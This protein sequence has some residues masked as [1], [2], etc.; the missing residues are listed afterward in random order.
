MDGQNDHPT[1]EN[2]H[3]NLVVDVNDATNAAG[4]HDVDTSTKIASVAPDLAA[5]HASQ[6]NDKA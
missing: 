4:K 1:Q 3:R 6:T 5:T 2:K